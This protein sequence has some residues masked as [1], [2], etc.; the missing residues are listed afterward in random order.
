MRTWLTLF[1]VAVLLAG[2][3]LPADPAD[4][5]PLDETLPIPNYPELYLRARSQATL[6]LEAFYAD[7]WADLDAA[8]KALEQTARFLPKSREVP[9]A[10]G[11]G[12]AKDADLLHKDAVQLG[13][14]ARAKDAR[15]ASDVLQRIQFNIRSLR[16]RLG[17][18]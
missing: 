10:L 12:L 15:T 16:P 7:G 1:G 5:K 14:A 11:A 18:E 8:A 2:C 4:L 17:P 3:R 6:A 13:D 9:A